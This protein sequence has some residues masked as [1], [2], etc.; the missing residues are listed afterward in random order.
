MGTIGS[1]LFQQILVMFLLIAVGYV[2]FKGKLVSIEGSKT[3]SNILLYAVSPCLIIN[4]YSI[5]RTPER[6]NGVLISFA[7][8]ALGL[9]LSIV[10]S[11]FFFGSKKRRQSHSLE[12]FGTAFSNAGFIGIPLVQAALGEEAVL[13]VSAFVAF[14]NIL[15]WTYGV[16]VITQ[17]REAIRPKKIFQNPVILS[18]VLSMLIFFFQIPL[19][20]VLGRTIA[21]VGNLNAPLAMMILGTYLAQTELLSIFRVPRLYV[22]SFLRLV[23]IPLLTIAVFCLVPDAFYEAKMATLIAA[24]APIGANVALFAQLNG[25]DYTYAVKEVCLCT[26]LCLFTMPFV[27]TLAEWLWK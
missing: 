24:S 15:Q 2:L 11:R 22:A 8:A 21:Y 17:S 9:L 5:E 18:M 10:V 14:L 12:H 23:V 6:V 3:L 25:K 7:L 26:L 1:I 16:V 27:M 13:Y 20:E 19:P 4:A